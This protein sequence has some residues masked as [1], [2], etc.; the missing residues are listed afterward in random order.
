MDGLIDAAHQRLEFKWDLRAAA[1]GIA[2]CLAITW[3]FF[4]AVMLRWTESIGWG[5]AAIA[6]GW[7][8][9]A[10]WIRSYRASGVLAKP[11]MSDD[12]L[13]SPALAPAKAE[14][15]R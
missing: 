14:V 1:A 15:A 11:A 13:P 5:A 7:A 4:T 10:C 8:Y 3:A 12:A 2:F 6:S 9:Y